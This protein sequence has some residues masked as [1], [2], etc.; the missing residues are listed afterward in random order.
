MLSYPTIDPIIF[1]IGPLQ[2]RGYGLAYV[3]GLLF[4]LVVFKHSFKHKL[5]LDSDQ[6]SNYLIWVML[7][8]ILGGRLGYIFFYNFSYYI[9]HLH[10]LV[11][12]W[13]GGMSFHGGAA[14]ALAAT[15]LFCKKYKINARQFSDVLVISSTIGLGLGRL[16]N[17]I[18]AELYGRVTTSPLGMVFPGGGDLP[19]HPSQLYEAFFEGL[20][21]FLI[22][23]AI[24]KTGKL[25]DGQL[26][27][28]FC[29]VY[30]TFRFGIE[31]F[32]EPDSHLGFIIA[33][34]SMGQLLSL[35]MF[36]LGLF[37]FICFRHPPT[38]SNP[39]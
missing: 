5:K 9:Q 29:M 18:N 35:F 20:L 26:M 30:A 36:G 22:L 12:L 16:A 13:K 11:Y 3:C 14:G 4:P 1:S 2:F 23:W 15:W 27:A 7:G 34:F 25:H 6:Q 24:R 28:V 39:R 17:F 10:E 19:R 37:F 21:L 33:T 31:Y 38:R 32:R 8:V